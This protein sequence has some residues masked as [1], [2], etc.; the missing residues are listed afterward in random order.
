M[1]QGAR[2][3][4]T[5]E[6]PMKTLRIVMAAA[7]LSACDGDSEP[8]IPDIDVRGNYALTELSFDPQGSL[9]NVDLRARTSLTIPRLVLVSDGR[10]QLIFED[11]ST[12]LVSTADAV[13]AITP[14]GDVR[15]DFGESA[16]A[17]RG[18]FLSRRMTFTYDQSIRSLIFA[19]SS[20]DGVD[21]QRLVALVPEWAQEQLFDPVPGTLRV[22]YRATTTQ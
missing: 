22:V 11:P 10:A 19:G 5:Q 21:R 13:Y 20:P 18:I 3:S 2:Q 16:T 9:P 7:L 1:Q 12:G 15:V 8:L 4:D 17:Q 14:Q 6:P